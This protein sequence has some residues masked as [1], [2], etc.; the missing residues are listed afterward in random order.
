[1]TE[2]CNFDAADLMHRARSFK[3]GAVPSNL[4]PLAAISLMLAITPAQA[5]DGY[6]AHGAGAKSKGMAGA[7]AALPQDALAIAVNPAAATD[8]GH[9]LDVG[10]DIFVP[11]RSARIVGNAAGGDKG[12]SGN[13]A[14]PFL[15]PEIGYVHPLSDRVSLGI[16]L[17][18]NG[19][20]NTDY[21]TNPF[22]HFGGKG[23][24][25]IDFK[26]AIATPTLAAKLVEGH[27]IGVSAVGVL[28][29]FRARGIAPFA[30]FS[31]DPANFTDKGTDWSV[32]TGFRV[33]YLGRWSDRLSVGAFYHSKVWTG[34]F[35][36][37][38]G[39][40]AGQ[41]S[42]DVPASWGGGIA[43][44]V[45]KR[46]D[47][48]ADVKR[49]EY[50]GVPAVGNTIA[51]LFAGM[52]FGER[53]APG[54]GWKDITV[55]KV[56]VAF[57]PTGDWTL[58]AGYGRSGQPIP[59]SQT[60]LNALAPGVVQDHF[61][62]GATRTVRSDMEITGHFLLAPRKAVEGQNSIPA[63]FGGGEMNVRL[64][65]VSSGI[66]VGFLF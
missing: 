17:Y 40:F 4:G 22:E 1:M 5:T 41:G 35:E 19:G 10:V 66:A 33:G 37:Y 58:R 31:A 27:S 18:G 60:F 21:K 2:I 42:F 9:R 47:V 30:A 39:L 12:Y 57:R 26:Q 11:L 48:A 56:G 63:A 28:Q 51:P 50:S 64:A 61:T 54:F 38:A 65:E 14:N 13:A 62:V 36:R 45:S 43:Y 23:R 16:A 59:R 34:K 6:F 29:S 32:G 55:Y 7:G 25:G 52:R 15:I 49:I 20:M 44:R 8:I 24:A 46:L 3:P 53:N